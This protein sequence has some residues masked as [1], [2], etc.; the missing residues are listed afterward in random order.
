MYSRK[1]TEGR[2]TLKNHHLLSLA[3]TLKIIAVFFFLVYISHTFLNK[4]VLI[5]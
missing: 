4:H 2:N 3:G 5:L 1:R